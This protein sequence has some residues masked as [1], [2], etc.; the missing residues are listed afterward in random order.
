MYTYCECAKR[1]FKVVHRQDVYILEKQIYI[2]ISMDPYLSIQPCC[3]N[4]YSMTK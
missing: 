2:Q 3:E 4:S 1:T